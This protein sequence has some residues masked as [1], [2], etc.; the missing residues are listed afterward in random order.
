MSNL[1]IDLLAQNSHL[2]Y[3]YSRDNA[4]FDLKQRDQWLIKGFELKARL[5]ELVGKEMAQGVNSEVDKAN[6]QLTII[7]KRL[8]D[9]AESLSKF[10]DT[11]QKITDVID[12]L[13]ILIGLVIPV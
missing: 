8:K 11:V 6:Q 7:S 2:C 9:K 10:A 5:V 13:D 3:E 1:K 4:T 12:I